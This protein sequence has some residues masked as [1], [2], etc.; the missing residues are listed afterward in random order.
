MRA[1]VLMAFSWL[2]AC[3][4]G[5]KGVAAEDLAEAERSAR[6]EYMVRCGF[7]PDAETCRATTEVD[8]ALVQALGSAAFGYVGYDEVAAKAWIEALQER[9]CERTRELARELAEAREAVFEGRRELGG[10]CFTDEECSG[11]AVCDRWEC[12]NNQVC[13]TGTCV[14]SRELAVGDTCP[15]PGERDTLRSACVEEAWCEPNEPPEGEPATTGT[16]RARMDNGQ[17]CTTH[18]ECLDGQLCDIGGRNQCY[19]LSE[20]DE[21]CNPNLA[22]SACLGVDQVCDPGQSQCVPL[23]GDGR[24]CVQGRCQPYAV[25]IDETCQRR[26]RRGEECEGGGPPCLGDLRCREGTCQRDPVV[27]VCVA[28][29]PPP[30]PMD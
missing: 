12:P 30:E 14:A 21:P 6:C 2:A 24:P 11:A 13:C 1:C 18:D 19:K 5:A 27:L 25:C 9:S 4:D 16:C 17:P 28:G 3:E 23:P 8:R 22:A 20:D 10:A 7:S 29:E 26:P 15:L